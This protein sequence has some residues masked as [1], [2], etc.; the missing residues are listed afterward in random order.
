MSRPT[1][2]CKK[3]LLVLHLRAPNDTNGNP[4]RVYVVFAPSP[5]TGQMH[6][7]DS[8]DEGYQ[9]DAAWRR[10]FTRE[11]IDG[12]NF[13]SVEVPVSEYNAWASGRDATS[14]D[15]PFVDPVP[16]MFRTGWSGPGNQKND[17]VFAMFPS[18]K[19]VDTPGSVTC[20]QHVGQHSSGDFSTCMRATR[21]AKPAEYAALRREL[22]RIG[23]RLRV[24]RNGYVFA[25]WRDRKEG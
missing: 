8:F 19:G 14:D 11:A 12:H 4:R 16:V 2:N 1:Y 5:K 15:S 3:G 13:V 23:Y 20:Y 17:T 7:V 21:P 10:H 24:V 25:W 6:L 18:L 9:G 22:E